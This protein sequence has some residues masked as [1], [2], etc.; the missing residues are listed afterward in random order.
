M[1]AHRPKRLLNQVRDAI[2]LKRYPY[3]TEQ[4]NA[5]KSR[6]P[7]C[8]S[9]ISQPDDGKA[10]AARTKSACAPSAGATA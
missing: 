5:P 8:T 9:P 2:R 4:T 10:S 6:F 1:E 7:L 3:S